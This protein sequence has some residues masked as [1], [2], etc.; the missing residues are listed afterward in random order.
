MKDRIF[1]GWNF[2]RVLYMALGLIVIGQAVYTAQYFLILFGAYFA[3]MGLFNFGCASGACPYV[4]PAQ[5][6][7]QG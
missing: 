1:S 7:E 5:K 3:S 6:K 4:P 2:R